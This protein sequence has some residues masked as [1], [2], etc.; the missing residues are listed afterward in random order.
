MAWENPS[1]FY[2]FVN[3]NG[4][5]TPSFFVVARSLVAEHARRK[6]IELVARGFKGS[7][8]D[9]ALTADECETYRDAW[10]LLGLET[11]D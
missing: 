2:V 8:H 10:H 9:F 7:M 11:A 5:S 6:H 3:L 4:M 1:W